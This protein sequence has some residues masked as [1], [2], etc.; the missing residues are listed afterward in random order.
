[1]LP[2]VTWTYLFYHV[3]LG[4]LPCIFFSSWTFAVYLNPIDIDYINVLWLRPAFACCSVKI[5]RLVN[6]PQQ[7]PRC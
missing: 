7:A 6:H 1:M 2:Q 5:V 3:L 4:S